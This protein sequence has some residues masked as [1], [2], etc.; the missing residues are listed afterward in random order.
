MDS[1]DECP[2]LISLALSITNFD[3]S[4]N[5]KIVQIRTLQKLISGGTGY[6]HEDISPAYGQ[7]IPYLE[8]LLDSEIDIK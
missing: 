2:Q 8:K 1:K 4:D 7:L 6:M 3:P 5:T